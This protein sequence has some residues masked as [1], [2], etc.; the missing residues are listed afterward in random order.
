MIVRPNVPYPEHRFVLTRGRYLGH[1]GDRAS[2]PKGE[3]LYLDRVAVT[4]GFVIRLPP[5]KGGESDFS[6]LRIS[7]C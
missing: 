1:G 4:I 5:C 7:F 6:R 2:L 3:V